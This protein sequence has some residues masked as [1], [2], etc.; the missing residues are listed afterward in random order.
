MS[1]AKQ[2]NN[3]TKKLRPLGAV[4]D[5]GIHFKRVESDTH[6]TVDLEAVVVHDTCQFLSCFNSSDISAIFNRMLTIRETL[7]Q[8]AVANV[9]ASVNR[10]VSNIMTLANPSPNSGSVAVCASS[11][12][13]TN[14]KKTKEVNFTESQTSEHEQ[15]REGTLPSL[16]PPAPP[17]TASAPASFMK[18]LTSDR[19]P[20]P[21]S[22]HALNGDLGNC[23]HSISIN[24]QD[25]FR[26]RH[27]VEDL[28][29]TSSLSSTET[30][31]KWQKGERSQF[32]LTPD[33]RVKSKSPSLSSYALCGT[34][35]NHPTA[36]DTSKSVDM[37]SVRSSLE[38][39]T[40]YG[41]V[42][43]DDVS[44]VSSDDVATKDSGQSFIQK[45]RSEKLIKPIKSQYEISNCSAVDIEDSIASYVLYGLSP[46]S[47]FEKN[48]TGHGTVKNSYQT[49]N[50]FP[51]IPNIEH[52]PTP[53]NGRVGLQEFTNEDKKMTSF[54]FSEGLKIVSLNPLNSPSTNDNVA[55]GVRQTKHYCIPENESNKENLSPEG[56]VGTNMLPPS[57]TKYLDGLTLLTPSQF[58][59]NMIA[60]KKRLKR[61]NRSKSVNSRDKF[62][63]PSPSHVEDNESSD[64]TVDFSLVGQSLPNLKSTPMWN[65]TQE[66][67]EPRQPV[68][69]VK[70]CVDE[71]SQTNWYELESTHNVRQKVVQSNPD[72]PDKSCDKK[73]I[74][75]QS[76]FPPKTKPESDKLDIKKLVTSI[77]YDS[78]KFTRTSLGKNNRFR[79]KMNGNVESNGSVDALDKTTIINGTTT[80]EIRIIRNKIPP[81]ETIISKN[82]NV[83]STSKKQDRI[84]ASSKDTQVNNFDR[85]KL[86]G[87]WTSTL[88]ECIIDNTCTTLPPESKHYTM[89]SFLDQVIQFKSEPE[90]PHEKVAIEPLYMGCSSQVPDNETTSKFHYIY[91]ADNEVRT[92]T[93]S[94]VKVLTA[95][96]HDVYSEYQHK[97]YRDTLSNGNLN[98]ATDKP[99]LHFIKV[100]VKDDFAI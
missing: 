3:G 57:S 64:V 27:K 22:R 61:L 97:K 69:G 42:N 83:N 93:N 86:D 29:S 88:N 45:N 66:F 84:P 23:L 24:N 8:V 20:P 63:F 98:T 91:N 17:N 49:A 28:K 65:V 6:C 15:H 85:F 87:T 35:L 72:N 26:T 36:K 13:G 52:L 54:D 89:R 25:N 19:S 39:K 100:R 30:S 47:T 79:N 1:K 67:N 73:F 16:V 4:K 11:E 37:L 56:I 62:R 74:L 92:G 7:R 70:L 82:S 78:A 51:S 55:Q 44:K 41:S 40:H 71:S 80:K 33:V 48:A 10:E 58:T 32:I 96:D 38:S 14:G 60:G 43:S 75:P 59:Q 68:S 2:L 99:R 81:T 31:D 90:E 95:L 34:A 53:R 18:S 46:V 76:L 5:K 77:S 50:R 9:C 94:K 12:S 21:S